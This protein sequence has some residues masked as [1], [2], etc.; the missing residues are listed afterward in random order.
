MV[1]RTKADAEATRH[2]LLDAAEQLFQSQGVSRTSLNDIAT[3]AG[4]TR[5]AIYWH[6]EDKADLFNA[7]MERAI[8]PMERGFPDPDTPIEDLA[9]PLQSLRDGMHH[10]LKLIA[11]DERLRR[12]FEVVSLQVE[13]HAEMAAVRERHLRVRHHYLGLTRRM[14]STAAQRVDLRLPVPLETAALG[15]HFLMD[16][17]KRNW[18]LD[19]TAFD[20][21]SVGRRTVDTYIAGLGFNLAAGPAPAPRRQ[22]RA[23]ASGAAGAAPPAP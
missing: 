12:V 20:L 1:R 5:G 16:G 10:V 23:P 7:M 2:A 3:A 17:L 21:V 11:G 19:P 13:Y 6:F 14:L 18:L 9:D 15:L 22:A 4:T 8:L